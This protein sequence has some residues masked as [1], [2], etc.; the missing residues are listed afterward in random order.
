MASAALTDQT[1]DRDRP[2]TLQ[3]SWSARLIGSLEEWP[4]LGQASSAITKLLEPLRG[5][6]EARQVEDL[7]HGRW[8]GHALHPVMVDLPIGFW[9]SAMLL[10]LVGAR[11]SARFLTAAGSV[12]AVG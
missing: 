3:A 6:P 9:T 2:A 7:L 4:P 1:P 8:L 12:S 5:R 10:E 11:K